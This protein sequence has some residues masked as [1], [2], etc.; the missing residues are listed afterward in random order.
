MNVFLR[1]SVDS[2]A[3][4]EL[5]Y[6]PP[7]VES[8][9]VSAPHRGV[10]PGR[11]RRLR[12]GNM[13]RRAIR[14]SL[15]FAAL[16][17][18]MLALVGCGG[19]GGAIATDTGGTI[20][21]S[22]GPAEV[23]VSFSTPAASPSAAGPVSLAAQSSAPS[24]DAGF[25]SPR[26]IREADRT[27]EHV[28]IDVVR[29]SLMPAAEPFV[30]ED[31]DGDV[32]DVVPADPVTSTDKPRFVS[33][34]PRRPVRIDLMDV[35]NSKRLARLLDRF[36]SVPAGTYDKIRIRYRRGTVVF[37][38]NASLNFRPAGS[39]SFDIHFR[40]GYELV[41]PAGPP[42]SLPDGWVKLFRVNIEVV[43]VK[44]KIVSWGSRWW[45]GARVV[46]RPE[47][48]AE[49]VQPTLTSVSM[50]GTVASVTRDPSAPGSGVFEVSAGEEA[51]Q[52][53]SATVQAAFDGNTTWHF[54]D[55]VLDGSSWV[56]D[57]AGA[58]GAAALQPTAI[59]EVQGSQDAGGVVHATDVTI[60]FPDALAGDADG[61]GFAGGFYLLYQNSRVAVS[62]LPD[63]VTAYYDDAT[64]ETH[65]MILYS[66][67]T[68]SSRLLVRGYASGS[69]PD[70]PTGIDAWWI[71][72][73]GANVAW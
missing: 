28:Y 54:S 24:K 21:A 20:A 62:P 15:F 61:V 9:P 47:I 43:G 69:A 22:A 11:Y 58:I 30:S 51:L 59:V 40:E 26:D 53:E 36:D 35:E 39:S 41:I 18:M 46:F 16:V 17:T 6:C 48:V 68:N 73:T 70:A 44:V 55:N 5:H 33:V 12:E 67:I 52:S 29:V 32:T 65:P 42:A 25:F 45:R 56:V 49:A 66:D 57:V 38:D 7:T 14:E 3:A 71:S 64:V 60:T 19:G 31:M 72:W 8:G 34:V 2:A 1:D 4:R 10:G 13:S 37:S 50:R 27:I 63:R 23:E